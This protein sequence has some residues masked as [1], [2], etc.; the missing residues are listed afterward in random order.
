MRYFA[1]LLLFVC[2]DTAYSKSIVFR[3]QENNQNIKQDNT[4]INKALNNL[5]K[6]TFYSSIVPGS[7]QYF[8]NNDKFKGMFL[9]GLEIIALSGYSYN[10]SKANKYKID[11]QNYGDNHWNFL[12]WCSKYYEWDVVGDEFFEI[13]SNTET[14]LYPDIWQDSHHINF[15]YDNAGINTFVSTSSSSFEDL[16][17]DICG[18]PDDCFDNM[19]N[20]IVTNNIIIEKD[21]HFYENIVKYN[22]FYA[23]WDDSVDGIEL[24]TT[25][26]GYKTAVSPSKINYRNI[27]DQSI[28]KYQ[29]SDIFLN[30]ILFNHFIS[31]LD[32]LIVSKLLNSNLSLSFDYNSK[33][34]FYEANLSLKLR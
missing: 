31:T 25:S 3:I 27:Y 10:K 20:F 11:Y 8:I 34:N 12:R 2:L 29:L 9:L 33:I 4:S 1:I 23:G 30:I 14:G 26:N 21:H 28:S 18:N 19:E 15:W 13:F 22:H 16:Y 24:S 7:G 32:A 5:A 6:A 17:T